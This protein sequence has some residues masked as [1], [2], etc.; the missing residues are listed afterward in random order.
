MYKKYL[1]LVLFIFAVSTIGCVCTEKTCSTSSPNGFPYGYKD[2][3]STYSKVVADKNSPFYGY[4]RVLVSPQALEAYK[5]DS[6][7]YK[8]GDVLILEF[9]EIEHEGSSPVKGSPNWIAK[10]HK[11][12]SAT[13]T[14]GWVFS[15][16]DS[17]TNALK[18]DI[19]P[20]TGCY[21][22]H[23]VKK[24]RDYVFSSYDN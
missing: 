19:D 9:S 10:M 4:V 23:I 1:L 14:G 12:T 15:G 8:N 21:N 17:K 7:G 2:W 18:K 24:N 22:C 3:T 11:D 13:K 5:N 20:I 16:F 6:Q